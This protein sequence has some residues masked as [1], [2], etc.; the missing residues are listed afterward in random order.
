MEMDKGA[1]QSYAVQKRRCG[2]RWLKALAFCIAF[3]VLME[4]LSFLF[5]PK[6]TGTGVANA[7]ARINGFYHQKTPPEVVFLGTSCVHF[8]I[9]NLKLF[10]DHGFTSY[11]FS[12][13][14]QDFS[15]AELYAKEALR[16]YDP[17]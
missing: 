4:V 14:A 13:P 9:D 15:A 8:D 10:Q 3:F 12:G 17:R 6:W 1:E 5:Q 2:S 7:Y 16:V 11:D